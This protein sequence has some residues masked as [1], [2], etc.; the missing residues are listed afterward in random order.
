MW[1]SP[2]APSTTGTSSSRSSCASEPHLWFTTTN[3]VVKHQ[4]L[5]HASQLL[6]IHWRPFLARQRSVSI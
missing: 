4:S 6:L 3:S 1:P 5:I 2:I